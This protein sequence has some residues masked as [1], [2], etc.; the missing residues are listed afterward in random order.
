MLT[1]KPIEWIREL[2]NNNTSEMRNSYL[3]LAGGRKGL[4]V[5]PSIG[6]TGKNEI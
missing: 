2:R 4:R 5:K 3:I 1:L 6:A